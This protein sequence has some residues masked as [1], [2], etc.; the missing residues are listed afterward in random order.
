VPSSMMP[1]LTIT[2]L[3]A[4]LQKLGAMK[5]D[6]AGR[7]F[8]TPVSRAFL[9]GGLHLE[10]K[11][12]EGTRVRTGRLRS[13]YATRQTKPLRVEVGTNTVYAPFVGSKGRPTGFTGAGEA[14]IAEVIKKE[15]GRV[16]DIV[17][18]GIREM[19]ES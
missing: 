7:V 15:K 1:S 14:H 12:K 13:S 18:Q 17:Q 10:G 6:Q 4:M 2:G 19:M 5:L 11:V 3:D 8:N 16:R 9:R